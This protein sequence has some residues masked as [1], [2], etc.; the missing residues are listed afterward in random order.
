MPPL[1]SPNDRKSYFVL[2]ISSPNFRRK[3]TIDF[4]GRR[5]RPFAL[6]MMAGPGQNYFSEGKVFG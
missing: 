1:N 6:R 2:E 3:T 4:S 5:D